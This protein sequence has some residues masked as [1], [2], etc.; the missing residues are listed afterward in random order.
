MASMGLSFESVKGA[1]KIISGKFGEGIWRQKLLNPD[2]AILG[3]VM[4]KFCLYGVNF[5]S[6][7]KQLM[8]TMSLLGKDKDFLEQYTPMIDD[9]EDSF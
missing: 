7:K 5:L 8:G 2:F 6:S 4:R 9:S 3:A 1:V